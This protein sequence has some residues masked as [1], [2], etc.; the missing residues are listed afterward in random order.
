MRD[1][2]ACG[3]SVQR[4]HEVA[5]QTEAGE[6]ISDTT[7]R[8]SYTPGGQ[9]CTHSNAEASI[10]H[11][12]ARGDSVDGAPARFT[13]CLLARRTLFCVVQAEHTFPAR[14]VFVDEHS[15]ICTADL[16]S[17]HFNLAGGDLRIEL[18]CTALFCCPWRA[19]PCFG[20]LQYAQLRLS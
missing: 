2:T 3:V 17:H 18:S 14:R 8:H 9:A 5:L 19:P 15:W 13:V 12:T 6:A 11:E 20:A 4:C 1:N 10:L 7:K 16:V